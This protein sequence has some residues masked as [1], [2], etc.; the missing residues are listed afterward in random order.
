LGKKCLGYSKG[1]L[2]AIE[3]NNAL[4]DHFKVLQEAKQITDLYYKSYFFKNS[5]GKVALEKVQE[6]FEDLIDELNVSHI[7]QEASIHT[8]TFYYL[9]YSNYYNVK[10]IGNKS[11]FILEKL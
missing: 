2:Q 9:I 5:V 6:D 1:L 3:V 7:S 11:S 10:K 4:G 8:T